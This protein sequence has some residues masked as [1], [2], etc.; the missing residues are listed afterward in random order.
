MPSLRLGMAALLCA[1]CG[2]GGGGGGP[3]DVTFHGED[4]PFPGFKFDT[5]V[6]PSGSP[7]Q[8]EL[9]LSA[10]GKLAGDALATAGGPSDLPVVAAK[11]GSGKYAVDGAFHFDGTLKVDVSG[12]PKYD[13]PIPMLSNIDVMFDGSAMFD[14]FL[15]GK[16]ATAMAPIPKTDLPPIPLPGGLPGTLNITI[17]DGSFVQSQFSGV[18]ADVSAG[19]NAKAQYTG[20]TVTTG[21]LKLQ[22]SVVLKVPIVGSKTYPIP[23][24]DVPIPP[25][26]RGLDLGTV[27]VMGGGDAPAGDTMMRGTCSPVSDDGGTGGDGGVTPD[28]A[29]ADLAGA[30]LA[31][32]GDGG[33]DGGVVMCGPAQN[34]NPSA[35]QWKAPIGPHAGDCTFA[36]VGSFYDDCIGANASKATCDNNFGPGT[37]GQICG[38]CLYTDESQ[39]ALGAIIATGF[40]AYVNVYGCMA[41]VDNAD[42]ACIK[43]Q[44]VVVNCE[45]ASC[46]PVCKP[47]DDP[48]SCLTDAD[49]SICSTYIT[50]AGQCTIA[51]SAYDTCADPN[52][53]DR[54]FF[55]MV[56]YAICATACMNN[57]QCPPGHTCSGGFCK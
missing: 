51:Q 39:P 19:P 54:D 43:S 9:V 36:Q 34:I 35:I 45:N 28:L 29:G 4:Q 46:E 33:G 38:D 21:M 20:Q 23:E 13:G 16:S 27:M 8:V 5:G 1:S 53:S 2:T 40:S 41:L 18:C 3:S 11:A 17:A 25:I 14:P 48:S 12:L 10:D 44:Q 24:V 49:N 6:Q 47:G 42:L 50:A 7:V 37:A 57:G 22:P 52:L 26:T 15:V 55:L 32:G 31:T 56:G 30:D